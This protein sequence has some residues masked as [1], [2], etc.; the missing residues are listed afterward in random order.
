MKK[1]VLLTIILAFFLSGCEKSPSPAASTKT[2]FE[3]CISPNN[4]YNDGGGHDAGFIWAAEN[5]GDCNG[6]SDSFNE[7]CAE[8]HRQLDEYNQCIANRQ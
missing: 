2:K 5:G 7:G 4:P 1:T 6:Y 8:F 3:D